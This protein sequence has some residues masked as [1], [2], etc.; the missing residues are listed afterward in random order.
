M[1]KQAAYEG[2]GNDRGE[3]IGI[4]SLL[5]SQSFIAMERP[6]PHLPFLIS[7]EWLFFFFIKEFPIKE[8]VRVWCVYV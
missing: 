8:C 1:A 6:R 3:R 5:Y 2:Y 4:I 7:F